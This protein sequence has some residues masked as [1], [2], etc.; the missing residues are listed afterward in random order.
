[1]MLYKNTEV[2]SPGY[3]LAPY[4]FIISI[5]NMLRTSVDLKKENG[6]NDYGHRLRCWHWQVYLAE[7]LSRIP[8]T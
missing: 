8:A 7:A 3:T 4:L 5:D 2:R 6:T 1:M